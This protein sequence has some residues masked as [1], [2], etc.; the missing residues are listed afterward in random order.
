MN[1]IVEEQRKRREFLYHIYRNAQYNN[2]SGGWAINYADTFSVI[3]RMNHNWGF[4]GNADLAPLIY[5]HLAKGNISVTTPDAKPPDNGLSNPV[6]QQRDSMSIFF[7][8]IYITEIGKTAVENDYELQACLI[9]N[10]TV[11]DWS[12]LE[13]AVDQQNLNESELNTSP[14][15]KN[16]PSETCAKE[17]GMEKH[18]SEKI[19]QT[20]FPKTWEYLRTIWKS[21]HQDVL[22][23]RAD[24][25]HLWDDLRLS[26]SQIESQ[27]ASKSTIR[28]DLIA[29][30]GANLLERPYPTPRNNNP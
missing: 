28:R 20:N 26:V 24:V 14:S 1:N 13:T 16:H 23:R 29:L 11:I 18:S 2:N 3:Y 12:K 15:D 6:W 21:K 17:S 7:K 5:D 10:G 4:M 30:H 27:I 19:E 22:K 8:G 9:R 25:W